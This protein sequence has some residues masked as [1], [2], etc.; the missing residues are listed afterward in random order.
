MFAK[1]DYTGK[2]LKP[3]LK[4][5]GG[6]EQ[7]LKYILPALPDKFEN[8]FEPFIG[9]GAVY[10]SIFAKQKFINDKSNELIDLYNAIKKQDRLFF[11]IVD[12]MISAWNFLEKLVFDNSKFFINFYLDFSKNNIN[13]IKLKEIIFEFILN[14]SIKL[15]EILT[16]N[17]NIDTEFFIKELNKNVFNK[18]KRMKKI[19]LEKGKLPNK[20][21]LDNIESAVKSGFYMYIRHLYNNVVEFKLG[22][23]LEISLFFFIRNFAYSGMFRYNNAGKFNVPYGGIGYNSKNLS[24][25]L[26]YLQSEKLI[27]YLSNTNIYSLDFEIFF[28]KV[29]PQKEDFIFLDP[30]YDSE[31]STYAKNEFSKRDQERLA[32]YLIDKCNAKWMLIIKNTDFIFNLYNNKK[33]VKIGVFDKTYLVSFKNRND[34]KVKHLLITNY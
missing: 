15:K 29:K 21:I 10:F 6:K 22:K 4:W 14:N 23:S 13:E 19:E 20:D 5:A 27:N 26:N 2:S 1:I 16:P 18:L 24:K 8:Y 11:E 33:N 31:F 17:L 32:N 12:E 30:P 7:E 9:G 34:K 28:N 25:K 3:I